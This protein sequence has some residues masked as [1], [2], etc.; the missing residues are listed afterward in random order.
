MRPQ[1]KNHRA[2]GPDH[3]AWPDATPDFLKLRER[4]MHERTLAI[5]AALSALWSRLRAN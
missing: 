1:T 3:A 5:N 2:I 4:A